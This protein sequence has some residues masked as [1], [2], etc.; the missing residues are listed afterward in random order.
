MNAPAAVPVDVSTSVPAEVWDLVYRLDSHALPTQ[1]PRWARAITASGGYYDVSRLYAFADGRRAILPL[2]EGAGGPRKL[3]SRLSPPSAWGFGGLIASD[4]LGVAHLSAILDDVID[5]TTFRVHVRPNPLEAGLWKAAAGGRWIAVPRLAHVLDLRPGFDKIW[6][7]F[8]SST[9]GQI[10]KA[11]R[12]GLDVKSGCEPSLVEAFH[13]LLM[14]S[15]DR[16]ARRQHEPLALARWRAR[17]RDPIDKFNTIAKALGPACQFRVAY[18]NGEPAAAILVLQERNAHY[19]RGAMD[20]RLAAPTSA[21]YLLH[22]LAIEAACNAGCATY[23]MGETTAGGTLARFKEQ[24]GA[25]AT[26]YA[27]YAF[28]RLPLYWLKDRARTTV[29]RMIGFRDA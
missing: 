21:N 17:G 1:S 16:W 5:N 15:V 6:A 22:R 29:K 7:G 18:H 23:H 19:T 12:A 26:P 20:E 9:R 13:G 14:R 28:E 3:R 4:P 27:E 8:R 2:F 24:F 11:E 25:V 10:R